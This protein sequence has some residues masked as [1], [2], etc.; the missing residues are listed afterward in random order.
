MLCLAVETGS[1]QGHINFKTRMPSPGRGPGI[2]RGILCYWPLPQQLAG[3]MMRGKAR[4][5]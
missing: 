2:D 4:S 3:L 1:V 5:P